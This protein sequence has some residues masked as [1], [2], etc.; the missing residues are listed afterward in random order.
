MGLVSGCQF[1][2]LPDAYVEFLTCKPEN[3]GK[4]SVR[5]N[6]LLGTAELRCRIKV[7]RV[8]IAQKE[9]GKCDCTHSWVVGSEVRVDRSD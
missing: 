6:R 3:Q 1:T 4:T 9:S 8:F 7:E 5:G 2:Q